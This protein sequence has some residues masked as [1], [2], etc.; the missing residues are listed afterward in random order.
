MRIW[1]QNDY[2]LQAN[3]LLAFRSWFGGFNGPKKHLAVEKA[4]PIMSLWWSPE[5][6][7]LD[8]SLI[9]FTPVTKIVRIPDKSENNVIFAYRTWFHF[10]FINMQM[11]GCFYSFLILTF[12]IYTFCSSCSS[13]SLWHYI[14]IFLKSFNT[15]VIPC[16]VKKLS[17]ECPIDLY[18]LFSILPKFA[19]WGLRGSVYHF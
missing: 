14:D 2:M 17:F 6:I 7:V 5:Y 4:L 10:M 13:R 15:N 3:V 8:F 16:K 1:I 18:I 12:S 11:L 19:E 9:R